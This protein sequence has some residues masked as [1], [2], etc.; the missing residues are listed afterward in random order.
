M[1]EINIFNSENWKQLELFLL[2]NYN[3][4]NFSLIKKD[5][6]C[7][8]KQT[9]RYVNTNDYSVIYYIIDGDIEMRFNDRI[10]L[11]ETLIFMRKD[12]INKIKKRINKNKW[13]QLKHLIK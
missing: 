5:R 1:S 8:V 10:S 9:A 2:Y 12:K 6:K 7:R 13:K 11:E 3:K 4:N